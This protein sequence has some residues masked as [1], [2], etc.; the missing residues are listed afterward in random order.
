VSKFTLSEAGD[1]SN[2]VTV[3]LTVPGNWQSAG[4][5]PPS[6]KMDGARSLSLTAI[7]PSGSDDAARVQKAIK[8]QY[9]DLTGATRN[10]Y[11]DGRVWIAQKDG[12]MVHAR[13]FVPYPTG[14][15]M[16]IAMLSD[17]SKVDSAKAAFETL[18]IAQ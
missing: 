11:P 17:E 14:V 5:N 12:A 13:M 10:D 16:G 7:G 4:D 3:E 8:L 1:D 15:V 9:D 18:K 2:K 6:W